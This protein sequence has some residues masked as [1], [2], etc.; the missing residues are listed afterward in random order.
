MERI[1]DYTKSNEPFIDFYKENLDMDI[2]CPLYNHLNKF[3]FRGTYGDYELIPSVLREKYSGNLSSY[4]ELIELEKKYLSKFLNFSNYNGLKIPNDVNK[5]RY[6]DIMRIESSVWI[7][8][9]L[10]ELAALAQHYGLPT[11]LLYWSFDINVALY[12]ASI[13]AIKDKSEDKDMKKIVIW[14]LNN[15]LLEGYKDTQKEPSL[16]FVVPSYYNNPNLNAQKGVLTVWK[17][18]KNEAEL[19]KRI[20]RIPL[21]ELIKSKFNTIKDTVI[22]KFIFPPKSRF[23]I[24]NHI[25]RF[26]YNSATRSWNLW[27]C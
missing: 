18:R 24:F 15:K 25:N 6:N 11:R 26:N 5:N 2:D 23:D 27:K 3:I 22:Y 14:A 12:F 21:N 13:E 7:P 16:G 20:E 17:R 8:D 9:E 1:C 10:E 19:S 4:Y